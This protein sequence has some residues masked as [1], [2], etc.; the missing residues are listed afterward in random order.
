VAED[1][2]EL[3]ALIAAAG[4]AAAGE[5][6]ALTPELTIPTVACIPLS[7]ALSATEAA[8]TATAAIDPPEIAGVDGIINAAP[9]PSN[10]AP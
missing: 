1:P 3:I 4:N 8:A 5:A 6:T 2:E 10:A 9:N 7:A